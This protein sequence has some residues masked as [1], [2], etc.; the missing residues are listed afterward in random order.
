MTEI[1]VNIP[2]PIRIEPKISDK[3]A[4]AIALLQSWR[5]EDATS[6]PE[7]AYSFS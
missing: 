2:P 1:H 7:P 5:E 4:A 3:N 6:D